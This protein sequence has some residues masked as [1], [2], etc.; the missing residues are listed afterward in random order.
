MLDGY[1]EVKLLRRV[2]IEGV[3]QRVT[4]TFE[5]VNDTF[6]RVSF[7]NNAIPNTV[8][9]V[10]NY[11]DYQFDVVTNKTVAQALSEDDF[12]NLVVYYAGYFQSDIDNTEDNDYGYEDVIVT[13][14]EL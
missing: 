13:E 5:Q 1:E 9:Y 14:I 3:S 2:S 11:H 7:E 12:N 8:F 4:L 6:T 10:T